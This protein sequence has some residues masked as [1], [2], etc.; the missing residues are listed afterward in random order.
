MVQMRRDQHLYH[1]EAPE[2][3]GRAMAK[4]LDRVAGSSLHSARYSVG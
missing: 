1:R 4:A 3:I 2:R